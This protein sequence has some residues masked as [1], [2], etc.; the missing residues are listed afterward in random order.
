LSE[1]GGGKNTARMKSVE[2][3]RIAPMIA[4]SNPNKATGLDGVT[5]AAWQAGGRLAAQLA[6]SVLNASRN[7]G[8]APLKL[9][10]G[11]IQD[12]LEK[13]GNKQLTSNSRAILIQP[14]LGK[15]HGGLLETEATSAY[16]SAISDA[17]CGATGGRSTTMAGLTAEL[18]AD[19]A[20]THKRSWAHLYV[21]LKA[22]FDMIVRELAFLDADTPVAE[23]E[24]IIKK[25]KLPD[26][27]LDTL[28]S[29]LKDG[30]NLLNKAGASDELCNMLHDLHTGT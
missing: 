14:F 29:F 24:A 26:E 3:D 27:M 8:R 16:T 17:Q 11:R 30:S 9:K 20:R 19:W 4:K 13:K 5:V 10:G 21:D 15:L 1:F 23:I 2:V 22:A 7:A 25:H 6:T 12:F 28:L 18:H